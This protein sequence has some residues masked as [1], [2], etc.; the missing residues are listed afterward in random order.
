[1]SWLQS[2]QELCSGV[3]ASVQAVALEDLGK[4]SKHV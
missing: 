1:M 2:V 4:P 3:A